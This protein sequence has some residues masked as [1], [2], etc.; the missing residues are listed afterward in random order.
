MNFLVFDSAKL[1]KYLY[2][3]NDKSQQ[4][5]LRQSTAVDAGFCSQYRITPTKVTERKKRIECIQSTSSFASM[6]ASFITNNAVSS[7]AFKHC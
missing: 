3:T 1:I 6:A 2:F 5:R 4:L 7:T